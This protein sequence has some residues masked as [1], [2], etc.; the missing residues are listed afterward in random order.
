MAR[1]YISGP[2]TGTHD[3]MKRF[4]D[5]EVKL[6]GMGYEVIN[7]AFI[8]SH[9]PKS[10]THDEYMKVCIAMLECCD[11]IYMLHGWRNSKGA[12]IEAEYALFNNIKILSEDKDA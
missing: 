12:K 4:T 9:L 10:F 8:N 3:Y 1:V 2:I 7:P 11:T 6:L 5:A